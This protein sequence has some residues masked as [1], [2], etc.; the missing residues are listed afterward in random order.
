MENYS[1]NLVAAQRS[2]APVH[3]FTK[4]PF[5]SLKLDYLH[6]FNKL[7]HVDDKGLTLLSNSIKRQSVSGRVSK[8]MWFNKQK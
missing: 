7:L 2:V 3:K 1:G 4:S 5:T 6:A 8:Y